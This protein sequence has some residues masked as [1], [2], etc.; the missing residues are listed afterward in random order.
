[1]CL[2]KS[3]FRAFNA[4]SGGQCT[5]KHSTEIGLYFLSRTM[6]MVFSEKILGDCVSRWCAKYS[7]SCKMVGRIDFSQI[8]C[9]GVG[10]KSGFLHGNET[11]LCNANSLLPYSHHLTGLYQEHTQQK[12]WRVSWDS[13]VGNQVQL[14]MTIS[15]GAKA[16]EYEI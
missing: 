6:T 7:A 14:I 11:E 16:A 13:A 10:L 3:H 1:M 12:C 9:S 8:L 2:T 4:L 5:Q 15:D